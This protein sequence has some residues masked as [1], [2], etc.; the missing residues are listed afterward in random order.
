MNGDA[1]YE[2]ALAEAAPARY[3]AYVSLRERDE[4][5]NWCRVADCCPSAWM[6]ALDCPDLSEMKG[7]DDGT[8]AT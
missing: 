8:D 5:C 3:A 6:G 4:R 7:E 2:H 1:Q